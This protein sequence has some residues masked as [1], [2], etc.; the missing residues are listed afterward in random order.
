MKVLR[1][2]LIGLCI[3]AA[4]TSA[5]FAQTSGTIQVTGTTPEAFSLTSAAEGT[6]S[7]TI[8]LSTLTPSNNNTLTVGTAD[9][10]LRSN[11]VYKVTAQA[12]ALSFSSPEGSDGGDTIA[13][14]DLG[15]GITS[16]TLTG[17]NVANSGSRTD[18]IA[19]GFD[20]TGGWPAATNGLTPV[21]GKTLNDIQTSAQVMNGTRISTKGNISTNNNFIDIQFGVATLPQFFTPNAGFQTTITL[22]IASN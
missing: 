19:T 7:S 3:G 17:A 12:G 15:F 1:K 14:T 5:A 2:L 8:A 4:F 21:F 13:L 11:K 16:K 9:V 22:T 18:T 20:V 6:L 10:H